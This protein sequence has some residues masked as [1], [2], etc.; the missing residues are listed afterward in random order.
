M[1]VPTA[2]RVFKWRHE[3]RER[4][5]LFHSATVTLSRHCEDCYRA[6]RYITPVTRLQLGA[7]LR[8]ESII[9]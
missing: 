9:G 6:C 2:T 4:D 5:K 3:Q 7:I 8:S 1:N